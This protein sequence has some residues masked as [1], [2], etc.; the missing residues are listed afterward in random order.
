MWECNNHPMVNEQLRLLPIKYIEGIST[1]GPFELL[2]EGNYSQT[3]Y[4]DNT[5]ED[6]IFKSKNL[7]LLLCF[8]SSQCLNRDNQSADYGYINHPCIR[9]AFSGSLREWQCWTA[10]PAKPRKTLRLYS[11]ISFYRR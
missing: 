5:F 9:T 6:T 2:A 10:V 8:S 4:E 7:L 11:D 3:N 1:A